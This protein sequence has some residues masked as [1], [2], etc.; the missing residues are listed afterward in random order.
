M[1]ER[2]VIDEKN[3]NEIKVI[4]L[5]KYDLRIVWEDK[6]LKNSKEQ[7]R[8]K[9]ETARVSLCELKKEGHNLVLKFDFLWTW[10]ITS[11]L[12]EKLLSCL[13]LKVK[14]CWHLVFV[15][16]KSDLLCQNLIAQT[17]LNL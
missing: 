2:G 4:G 3:Q 12:T 16:S 1:G 15:Y 17:H 9:E 13:P 11:L 5:R 7:E 10:A 8:K 6:S 14:I